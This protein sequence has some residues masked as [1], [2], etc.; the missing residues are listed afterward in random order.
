LVT[1]I[2]IVPSKEVASLYTPSE[3]CTRRIQSKGPVD[4][5]KNFGRRSY[6]FIFQ[7]QVLQNL[8]RVVRDAE[9]L[10]QEALLLKD[11]MH[12]VKE[13]I[14]KVKTKIKSR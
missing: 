14:A 5:K 10:N 8:P 12:S 6:L 1:G 7:Y 3:Q 11:K 4:K 2:F 13:E 9:L